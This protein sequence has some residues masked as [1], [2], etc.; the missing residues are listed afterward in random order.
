MEVFCKHSAYIGDKII[1]N[2]L[3]KICTRQREHIVQFLCHGCL[4]QRVYN[5]NN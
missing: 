5:Y 4:R 2:T 3:L 1:A